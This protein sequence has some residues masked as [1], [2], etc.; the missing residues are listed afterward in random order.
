MDGLMVRHST[1]DLPI[2]FRAYSNL[3]VLVPNSLVQFVWAELN[4]RYL[5]V[6]QH[7][8]AGLG[9]FRNEFCSGLL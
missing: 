4:N 3:Q 8:D 5:G 6:D 9:P 1:I 7:R 2:C